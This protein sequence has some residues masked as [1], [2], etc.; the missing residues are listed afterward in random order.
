MKTFKWIILFIPSIIL[1]S[2]NHKTI[3]TSGE[4]VIKV[5]TVKLTKKEMKFPVKTSGTLASREEY[6]LSFKTGGI[7]E[8]ISVDEGQ[9]VKKGQLLARLNLSEI[10][11][12]VKQAELGYEKA[13]RDHRR[14][15]NLYQDSVVTLE[16]LQNA[17]TAMQLA[18]SQL[19]IARFNREH[20]VITAPST[21]R[22]LKKLS[23]E[24]ELV[25]SGQPV[26]LFAST[27]GNWV[28]RCSVTDKD[29]VNLSLSDSAKVVFDAFRDKV[30]KGVVSELAQTAD[31]YTGTYEVEISI[32][33]EKESFVNGLI[34]RVEI[35][36]GEAGKY[37]LI[38]ADAMVEGNERQGFIYRVENGLAKKTQ[39]DVVDF[40]GE[41]LVIDDGLFEGLEIVV[42]GVAY[43]NNNS[44]V[45]VAK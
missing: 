37:W 20:S 42:E 33:N 31:P 40:V 12:T 21:G 7:I 2:C 27:E 30:F 4:K 45:E 23:E 14:V 38:P 8:S 17:E 44:K 24:N 3:E 13:V 34:G 6:K 5:T 36:S 28:V 15:S 9:S 1:I 41:E 32:M 29:I 39:V 19:T 18:K 22:I 11:A 25:G 35:Y 43:L 10:E 26:F 16:Q